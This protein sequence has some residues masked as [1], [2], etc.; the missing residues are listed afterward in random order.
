MDSTM[1]GTAIPA[2]LEISDTG[3]T[4]CIGTQSCRK[5]IQRSHI[6]EAAEGCL[7]YKQLEVMI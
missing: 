6:A 3:L 1:L 2:S 4:H 7:N 5:R